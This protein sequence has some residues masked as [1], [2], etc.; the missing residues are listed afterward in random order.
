MP[1]SSAPAGGSLAMGVSRCRPPVLLLLTVLPLLVCGAV[2]L[3]LS[4]R[5]TNAA[6]EKTTAETDRSPVDLLLT[7]DGKRL[8][9]VNQTSGTVSLIEIDSGKVVSEIA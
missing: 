9:T 3:L 6:A 7:S 2:L 4:P 5:S 8:L 1:A